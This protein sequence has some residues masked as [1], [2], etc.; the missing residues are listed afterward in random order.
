MDIET[1]I[2]EPRELKKKLKKGKRSICEVDFARI[3]FF[4][5]NFLQ[6]KQIFNLDKWIWY[7]YVYFL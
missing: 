2:I 5:K 7:V 6:K 3:V 1:G 4:L